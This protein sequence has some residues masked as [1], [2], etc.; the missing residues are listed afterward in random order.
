ME[1]PFEF[2]HGRPCAPPC[3]ARP[4]RSAGDSE[5]SSAS[6][7]AC[8]PLQKF[9]LDL[10]AA[11]FV[12]DGGL[13]L[14]IGAH[15]AKLRK[16]QGGLSLSASAR[17]PS[18]ALLA[19][20][21]RRNRDAS[22]LPPSA[23]TTQPGGGRGSSQSAS[24]PRAFAFV[25]FFSATSSAADSGD[26]GRGGKGGVWV[27]TGSHS[28]DLLAFLFDCV[29]ILG[30]KSAAAQGIRHAMTSLAKIEQLQARGARTGGRGIDDGEGF[31]RLYVR[32]SRGRLCGFLKVGKKTL[33]VGTATGMEKINPVSLLD[34]YV[35]E[36]CQREGHGGALFACMLANERLAAA[37]L[38]YDRPSPKLFAFLDKHYGLRNYVP[39]ANNF[40]VFDRYFDL[41]THQTSATD[42][43]RAR[44]FHETGARRNGD[45]MRGRRETQPRETQL[46][47]ADARRPMTTFPS[48]CR[49]ASARLSSPRREIGAASLRSAAG[50]RRLGDFSPVL[51]AAER[52]DSRALSREASFHRVLPSLHSAAPKAAERDDRLEALAGLP[53]AASSAARSRHLTSGGVAASLNPR[54]ERPPS[55]LAFSRGAD[56]GTAEGRGAREEADDSARHSRLSLTSFERGTH[57]A[58]G[59]DEG[60]ATERQGSRLLSAAE[61]STELPRP[62]GGGSERSS[63]EDAGGRKQTLLR[64]L[65]GLA[66]P[67]ASRP[68]YP[69]FPEKSFSE[70]RFGGESCPA[71]PR[72]RDEERGAVFAGSYS[73][74]Q[75][76]QRTHQDDVHRTES[77][78]QTA[79]ARLSSLCASSQHASRLP[80]FQSPSGPPSAASSVSSSAGAA[81]MTR[82]VPRDAV[83]G[84]SSYDAPLGGASKF[85][86]CDAQ[87][88]WSARAEGSRAGELDSAARLAADTSGRDAKQTRAASGG[89]HLRSLQ[90]ASALEGL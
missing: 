53:S 89:A 32:L 13:L 63:W 55:R 29:D 2:L 73:Q 82:I 75:T 59:W 72:E 11:T 90:V 57:D 51:S 44:S 85:A 88:G 36:S 77:E 19:E 8:E 65:P 1:V 25:E 81:P 54:T 84:R 74:P 33:W 16:S 49:L 28:F 14:Q 6:R 58:R 67:K 5:A 87:T 68:A 15:A 9:S 22:S 12:L 34:F 80:A 40:V 69:A 30:E 4:S 62:A 50:G 71:F 26:D 83:R 37:A 86:P 66:V 47:A 21:H 56:R 38:A 35:V 3:L 61:G 41:G 79:R 43:Q 24:C 18:H 78:R 39:Q 64:T 60:A 17:P 31:V 10:C 20:T 76:A 48:G 7:L 52:S 70:S 46:V 23:G 27:Q 42:A 45:P